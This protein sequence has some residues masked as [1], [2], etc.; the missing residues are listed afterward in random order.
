M[1]ITNIKESGANNILMWAISNGANVRED[2]PLTSLI[3]DETFYLVT[4]ENINFFELFRLTQMY[5]DKLRIINEKPAGIPSMEDLKE[6]FPGEYQPDPKEESLPLCDIAK[7]A[8]ESFINLTSQMSTD[9]DIIQPGAIRLFL[10]MI[11]RK[12]DVQI[13]IAFIDFIDSMDEEEC[14]KIFT[15]EYPATIQEIID[16]EVHGVKTRLYMG[17]VKSTQIL[18]YDSR[19]DQ[20]LKAIKYAPIKAY[21]QSSKLYKFGLC[22]FSKKDNIT[23]GEVRCNLFKS[24]QTVISN[25]LSR[26]SRL[27]TPLELD[28][29][30]QLPI[31]YM[32]LLE[33]SLGRE[34]LTI[35]Y[36]SSMSSIIDGGLVYDDFKTIDYPVDT[37]DADAQEKLQTHNNAIDAYRVR[38]TEANQILLNSI[39]IMA[40]S[41]SDVDISSVFAMLPSIYT[42]K[43]IIT[44]N[45]DDIQKYASHSDPLLA[46]MFEEMN[47]IAVGVNEDIRKLK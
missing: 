25:T 23:R 42:A 24:N 2:V 37:D 15:A 35:T 20:Y 19:Y 44:I 7:H 46:E 27:N 11:T 40:N 34:A 38:I 12:F 41:P 5:R 9:N 18:K 1:N 26:M 39:P 32:Q 47:T 28:F 36:E 45:T 10:P 22:G 3:N 8:I 16:A 17:L 21:S 31:Q 13:P 14:S 33:N 30:I 4:L 6:A 29:A 43:A